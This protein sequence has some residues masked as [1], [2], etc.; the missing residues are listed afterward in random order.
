VHL[1][2]DLVGVGVFHFVKK[3]EVGVN[4]YSL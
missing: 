4:M 1:E 2:R 3:N